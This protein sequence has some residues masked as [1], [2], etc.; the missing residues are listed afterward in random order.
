MDSTRRSGRLGKGS[1]PL[2]TSTQKRWAVS[3]KGQNIC[4][5][6]K[7]RGFDSPTVHKTFFCKVK[8]LLYICIMTTGY[9]SSTE[10]IKGAKESSLAKSESSDCVVRAIASAAEMDYDSAHQFVKETFC[11][12]NGKGTSGF[13]YTMNMMT[14][15]G[16]KINGKSVEKITEEHNTMLYY[17]VVKGVKKLRSTTTGS[18]IKKYSKGTYVVTVKGHAFT[19][20]D[21]VVIG[22]VEDGKKMKKHIDGVWKIG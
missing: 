7:R 17:V 6:H 12:K 11:R 19:I 3:S 22:N 8:Y 18:F 14:K 21:G 5:R 13:H 15:N 4:F 10:F 9:I 1:I 16:N 20:K 2:E